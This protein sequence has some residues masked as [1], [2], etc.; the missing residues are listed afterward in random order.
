[1]FDKVAQVQVFVPVRLFPLSVSF[2]QSSI[3]IFINVLQKD[4]RA[5]PGSQETNNALSKA[6]KGSMLAACVLNATA[7]LSRR[8]VVH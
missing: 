8:H 5:K 1:M 3:A 6:S 4:K 7:V 2:Q